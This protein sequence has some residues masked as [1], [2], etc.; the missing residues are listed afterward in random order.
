MRH[1]A[2]VTSTPLALLRIKKDLTQEDLCWASGMS[3]VT[4]SNYETGKSAPSY[5]TIIRLSDAMKVSPVTLF[6]AVYE[7]YGDLKK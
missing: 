3:S 2:K 6:K 7:T 5:R 1:R 4:V